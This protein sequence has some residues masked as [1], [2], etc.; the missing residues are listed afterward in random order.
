[1]EGGVQSPTFQLL[2]IHPGTPALVHVDLYR[3]ERSTELAD[4]GLEEQLETAVVVVEWGDRLEGARP[5]A[6]IGFE[7]LDPERRRLRLLEVPST[8]SW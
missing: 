2:R 7:A 6:R 1:M 8:W 3:L 4:L 5:A